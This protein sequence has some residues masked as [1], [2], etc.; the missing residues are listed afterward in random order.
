MPRCSGVPVAAAV[1][2]AAAG[3]GAAGHQSAGSVL[4][5]RDVQARVACGPR[6]QW[7][8][9]GGGHRPRNRPRL[10]PPSAAAAARARARARRTRRRPR[11]PHR[12]ACGERRLRAPRAWV[13]WEGASDGLSAV[14]SPVKKPKGL[15]WKPVTSQGI[16]GK[17]S[18]RTTW[19]T[20]NA[21]HT[22]GSASSSGLSCGRR[23]CAPASAAREGAD[24]ENPG[25]VRGGGGVGSQERDGSTPR[26]RGG[27]HLLGVHAQPGTILLAVNIVAGGEALLVVVGCDPQ[28]MA[29]KHGTLRHQAVWRRQQR[30]AGHGHQLVGNGAAAH[31][32]DLVGVLD[33]HP[34]SRWTLGVPCHT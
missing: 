21:Y 28:V 4:A 20:P 26:C 6:V 25:R 13:G 18:T 2:A 30:R 8:E 23:A 11:L 33:L 15:M 17:S 7:E 10:P 9:E 12:A 27:P 1:G 22:T 19:V 14:V 34:G 3:I 31:W 32:V 24:G 16:T 29:G 5:R